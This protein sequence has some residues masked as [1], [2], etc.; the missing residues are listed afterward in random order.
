M[1]VEGGM[2]GW[3]GGGQRAM[4]KSEKDPVSPSEES[5]RDERNG[6]WVLGFF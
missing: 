2:W 1:E 3:V 5:V 4:V 6:C